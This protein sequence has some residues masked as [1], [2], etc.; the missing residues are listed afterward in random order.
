MFLP[1]EIW[2]VRVA[3]KSAEAVVVMTLVERPEER[4]AEA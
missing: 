4:R 2:A 3:Q 1:G